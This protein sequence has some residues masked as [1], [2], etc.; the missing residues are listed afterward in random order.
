VA[1]SSRL[2]LAAKPPGDAVLRLR[3]WGRAHQGKPQRLRLVLNDCPLG[4]LTLGSLP[5][6]FSLPVPAGCLHAAPQWLVFEADHLDVPAA[7]DP[8][9]ADTRTL[10][11]ALDWLALDPAP[12][13]EGKPHS[14]TSR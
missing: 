5:A 2:P 11:F 7:S 3:A 13:S 14:E 9:S 8:A 1:A 10:A 6:V 4:E 12:A